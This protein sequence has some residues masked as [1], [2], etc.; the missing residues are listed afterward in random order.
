MKKKIKKLRADLAFNIIGFIVLL[1]LLLSLITGV[2]G[3]AGFTAAFQKEYAESTFHMANTAAALVHGD[4]LDSYLTDSDSADYVQTKNALDVFC[5]RMSVS[6]VYVIK[7]DTS[8]YGRF[9]SVFNS[10]DNSVDGTSYTPW[11]P[12][13]RRETT[14]DEYRRKY[15]A[16]YEK[17]QPY[18]TVYRTD[19][20]KGQRPHIT[21]MVPV[22][23]SAGQVAALLCIQR[24]MSELDSVRRGYLIQI[25]VSTLLIAVFAAFFAA[26][27]LK[28]QFVVPVRRVSEEAIRFAKENTADAPLGE[29]SRFYELQ[30]LARSIDTMETDMLRYVD[31]LTAATAER[32]RIGAEL[33]VAR[34]IQANAVP[35]EFPAS[36]RV[37]LF[38]SMTPA[39][40]VGGDFYNFFPVGDDRLAFVIGDVSGKGVPAA[41][42]MM[43][44]N[45]LITERT[46][47]GGTP[48]EI[49]RHVNDDL[50]AHNQAEMFVTLWLGILDLSTGRVTAANAGHEDAA[51]YRRGGSFERLKTKHGL[52]AGSIPGVRYR[53]FE[54]TLEPGD[55]LFLYTDG[56]PEATDSNNNLFTPARMYEALNRFC[57]ASPRDILGGVSQSV[58][59]FVG[60][61]PQFD[62][63]TM[64]CMEWKALPDEKKVL[65]VDADVGSLEQV[66]AFF[67]NI[68]EQADCPMKAQMQIRLAAE[69]IFVNIAHYAYGEGKGK[70]EI[71]AF[72]ADDVFEARF[73]DSGVPFDPLKKTDPDTTLGAKERPIGGLGIFLVKKNMD[74]VTYAR[75]DNCNVLTIRK[76]LR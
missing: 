32:E 20:L 12:G 17:Q 14:N 62:D 64:F 22:E 72:V 65:T 6:L 18:E 40:E 7:V 43:V 71:C 25:M 55:K 9:V 67:D 3:Y 15:K 49:L 30:N 39:K 27:F 66:N 10:V 76:K 29:V 54:I 4:R 44:T 69:E 74:E 33:A 38:A 8:D 75:E 2:V 37:E 42:F 19:H 48:A 11:E 28:N 21:T 73:R 5:Q 56:V 53:D 23:D 45:I 51:L 35:T 52:L 59:A 1:L 26:G 58:Q 46:K 13:Y 36:E 41:L 68:L 50:C 63:L 60:S 47:A 61:A 24:P 34:Q 16:L 31:N 57:T 70:A